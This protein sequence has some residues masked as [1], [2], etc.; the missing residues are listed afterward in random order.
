VDNYKYSFI[1]NT[2]EEE[3]KFGARVAAKQIN[4]R[5]SGRECTISEQF[6]TGTAFALSSFRQDNLLFESPSN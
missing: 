6:K 3:I 5:F 2:A 4:N 1:N